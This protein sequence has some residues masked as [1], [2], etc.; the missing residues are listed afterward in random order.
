MKSTKHKH[1]PLAYQFVYP[2][3]TSDQRV[4]PGQRKIEMAAIDLTAALIAAGHPPTNQTIDT[5]IDM[6]C[7][8]C[9][10]LEERFGSFDDPQDYSNDRD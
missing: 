8:L 2:T 7:E 4:I 3:G 9:D 5:G 6:A 10:T 1:I